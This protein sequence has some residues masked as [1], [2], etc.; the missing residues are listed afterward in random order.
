MIDQSHEFRRIVELLLAQEFICEYAD[1][2]A[3]EY[4]TN[5]VYRENVDNFL[6]KIGRCLR[7]T[8]DMS[9]Y[10][11]AYAQ[12]SSDATRIQL[13][14]QFRD[15]INAL[16][17]LVRWLSLVMSATQQDAPLAPGD[18][19]RQG[20]LLS[21]VEVTP[22]LVEDLAQITRAG[23]FASKSAAAKDQLSQVL[24]VLCNTGYLLRSSPTSSLYTAAG[25]WSYL[26]EVL[27][28][29]HTH[30]ELSASEAQDEQ[31]QLGL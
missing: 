29:I 7:Q 10:Y 27:E 11:C 26:F 30:E 18:I 24:S 17:P 1:K 14:Q 2:P 8:E 15:T 16:E 5:N 23:L 20:E 3:F 31:Q 19:I 12:T 21:V 9:T 6:R 22:A 25:K 4:L 28:F 13:R